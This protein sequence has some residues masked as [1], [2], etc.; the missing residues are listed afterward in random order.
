L[1]TGSNELNKVEN[2]IELVLQQFKSAERLS[3]FERGQ[4]DGLR[5]ALDVI[6]AIKSPDE[7]T[8]L[9]GARN[10]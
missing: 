5:W 6:R 1:D 10:I 3:D 4:A 7:L 9:N 8:A 2:G